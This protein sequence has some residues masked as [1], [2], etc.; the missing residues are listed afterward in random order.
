MCKVDGLTLR[1]EQSLNFFFTLGISRIS[2]L[3]G[4]LVD[5]LF[6]FFAQYMN[7]EPAEGQR[8]GT[9]FPT[10]EKVTRNPSCRFGGACS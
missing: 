7:L 4:N 8:M 1:E 5:I 3:E 2:K 9:S 6:D 10:A